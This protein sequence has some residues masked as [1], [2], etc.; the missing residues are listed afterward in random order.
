MSICRHI[1]SGADRQRGWFRSAEMGLGMSPESGN[2]VCRT[3]VWSV[4]VN[5]I[6]GVRKK[7]PSG[8]VETLRADPSIALAAYP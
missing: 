8:K 7:L 2:N 1:V 3:A 6:T 5:C 4:M